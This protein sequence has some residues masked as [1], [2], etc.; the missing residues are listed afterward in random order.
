ML[1]MCSNTANILLLVW[2]QWLLVLKGMYVSTVYTDP[3]YLPH[4]YINRSCTH[5][6]LGSSQ[7]PW[8]TPN[9]HQIIIVGLAGRV[10]QRHQLA[11]LVHLQCVITSTCQTI[12]YFTLKQL[13]RSK[14]DHSRREMGKEEGAVRV[15]PKPVHN[16]MFPT[17]HCTMHAFFWLMNY[18][19][20]IHAKPKVH[21]LQDFPSPCRV[22]TA[23]SSTCSSS[24]AAQVSMQ[25]VIG[26]SPTS[27]LK[28]N[29]PT[30]WW[31]ETKSFLKGVHSQ[32][33]AMHDDTSVLLL[34]DFVWL[35]Q[36][37]WH[38]YL[39]VTVARYLSVTVASYLSVTVAR[40]LSVTV[41]SYLSVTVARWVLNALKYKIHAHQS[42]KQYPST[43]Q[44]SF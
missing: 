6:H 42:G 27:N 37:L 32:H 16:T 19:A 11:L 38:S 25:N 18:L 31:W 35:L 29:S 39:S 3:P 36:L 28:E 23:E 20:H 22:S 40:Y 4:K 15:A 34:H 24:S 33:I 13:C 43:N 14:N 41:A 10:D 30:A 2:Q 12:T 17:A 9:H 1:C 21:W 26:S 5:A 7:A 44:I 8:S